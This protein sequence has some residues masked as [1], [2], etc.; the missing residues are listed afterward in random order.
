M[1]E[2]LKVSSRTLYLSS[3]LHLNHAKCFKQLRNCLRQKL[4]NSKIVLKYRGEIWKGTYLHL[5]NP[6]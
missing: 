4:I 3:S 6:D 5:E 1:I 2:I